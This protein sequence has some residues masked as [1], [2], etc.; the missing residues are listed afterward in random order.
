MPP[1]GKRL[2]AMM[3]LIPEG[4][5]LIDVGCDHARLPIAYV[6]SKPVVRAVAIDNKA[7][8]LAIAKQNVQRAGVSERV[9][10]MLHDGVPPGL[11]QAND[12][13]VIA[14]LG[15][16][17]TKQIIARF[18]RRPD[19]LLLAP[20]SRVATLRRFLSEQRL[21]IVTEHVLVE[22]KRPYIVLCV[23]PHP[24]PIA[25]SVDAIWL[26]PCILEHYKDEDKEA[27]RL[28]LLRL[29]RHLH[30]LVKR[31]PE[32]DAVV[33]TVNRMLGEEHDALH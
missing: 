13:V 18:D 26:G 24:A 32:L 12:T 6:L 1:L 11:L 3:S 7:Q 2:Q 30:G 9:Q 16:E 23:E 8:P 31:L 19:R 14:G 15:G 27:I 5:R 4:H 21:K 20:H 17:E 10:V 33:A 25:L 22:A 28:Y 29:R